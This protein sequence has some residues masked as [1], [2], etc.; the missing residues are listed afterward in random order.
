[1]TLAPHWR[2]VV[3]FVLFQAVWF[4]ATF[5]AVAGLGLWIVPVAGIGLWMHLVLCVEP[6]FRRSELRTIALAGAI[7]AV[8]D[9]L[10]TYFG[11]FAFPT[12]QTSPLGV[13]L[14]M[15]CLWFCFPIMLGTT[16]RW[17]SNRFWLAV[18]L[19]LVGGPLSYF[20]GVRIGALRIGAPEHLGYLWVAIVWGAFTP[21][22]L[23]IH[24]TSRGGA[25]G[26]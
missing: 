15:W 18:S 11:L 3:D 4:A 20:A 10:A 25:L 8:T 9:V 5:G 2:S 13:P 12:D 19:G 16:L 26:R 24:G 23:W 17:L 21:L 1:M 14:W 7:G 6:R 22:A